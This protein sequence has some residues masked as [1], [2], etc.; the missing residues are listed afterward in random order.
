MEGLVSIIAY[1]K[2]EDLFA[3]SDDELIDSLA[4]MRASADR[5]EVE[6]MRRVHEI[7]ARRLPGAEG[8][9]STTALLKHRCRMSA[10]RA[11]S[12]V[13]LGDKLPT[14][15]YVEKAVDAGD[16]SLDQAKVLGAL[17][18]RLGDQL[19]KDEVTL[20][21]AIAPLSVELG[22]RIV[23]YWKAAVDGPGNEADAGELL[24]RRYLFGSTTLDGMVKLDGLLDPVAGDLLLTALQAATPPRREGD[25]RSPRQRR[26]DALA[27]LARTYLDSGEAPGHEKPHVLVLTDLH[28][29]KGSGGGVHETANGQ[30]LTPEQ[31][32]Q[33]ACDATISRVVFGSGSEP[34]DVGRATRVVPA[35]MR[36]A[37]IAR[38]RHCRFPGCDRPSQWCDAHHVVHWADGGPTALWNLKLLCRFHHTLEH[39]SQSP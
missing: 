18:D 1:L 4:D 38:D 17:P 8:Y 22:R 13:A 25:D 35:A 31:V 27:D 6:W 16:L 3:L 39:R 34:V 28:A 5:L 15:P 20:V 9:T 2:A 19:T 30:V 14:M 33:T 37:I 26:A 23:E 7:T 32:R 11:R 12:A 24:D 10:S 36:R 21:N 29:L